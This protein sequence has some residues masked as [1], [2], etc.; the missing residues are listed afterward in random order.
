M[1]RALDKAK[2]LK[3]RMA[4]GEPVLGTQL[5]FHDSASIEIFGKAGFDWAHIDM[6]HSAQSLPGMQGVFQA[7]LGWGIV[8]LVRPLSLNSAEI[9][10]LL[11]IGAGGILCPFVESPEQAQLLVEACLYPPRGSRGWGPVRGSAFQMSTDDYMTAYAESLII[12]V[13]IESARG[14]R[15]SEA[16][17]AVEGIDG[18][19][20]GPMDLS[21]D[22]GVFQR[23]D[24]PL[25]VEAVEEIRSAALTNGKPFGCGVVDEESAKRAIAN[26]ETILLSLG[27]TNVLGNGA[28]KL[29][30][31]LRSAIAATR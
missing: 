30:K 27:D 4:S 15:N 20:V 25:Y 29:A 14:A 28:S 12:L 19:L 6:E 10:R 5:G 1:L 16:I 8:P 3:G 11:D 9:G 31:D 17:L 7:A 18:A 21:L 26:K 2:I 13:I 24:H 22:L 23:W